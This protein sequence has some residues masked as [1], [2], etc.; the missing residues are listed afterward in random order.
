MLTKG[1]HSQVL[2]D[3]LDLYPLTLYRPLINTPQLTRHSIKH[4]IDIPVDSWIDFQSMHMTRLTL[5]QVSA[6]C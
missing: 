1:I 3:T 2:M 6:N 5:G 4:S